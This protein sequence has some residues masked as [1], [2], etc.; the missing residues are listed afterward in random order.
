MPS[1]LSGT[2]TWLTEAGPV[3]IEVRGDMVF[4]CEGLDQAS[5]EKLERD[6]FAPTQR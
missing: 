4:V 6:S 5:T 2:H 3:M 1:T